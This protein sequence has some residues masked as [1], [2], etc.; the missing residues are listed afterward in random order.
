MGQ[1]SNMAS[2]KANGSFGH[3]PT[4][5]AW[6]L[7]TWRGMASC[8]T[9]HSIQGSFNGKWATFHE[10]KNYRKLIDNYVLLF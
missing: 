10:L 6:T 9:G 1:G 4:I 2:S 8:N 3:S 7:I 5:R